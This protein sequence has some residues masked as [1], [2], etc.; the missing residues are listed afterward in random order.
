MRTSEAALR[1]ALALRAWRRL[2]TWQVAHVVRVA[3][4]RGWRA[5]RMARGDGGRSRSSARPGAAL[6]FAVPGGRQDRA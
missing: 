4:W 2:L 5:A 1:E 3:A 6:R